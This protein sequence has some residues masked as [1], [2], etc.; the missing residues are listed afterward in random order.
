L[1]V[2]RRLAFA[3]DESVT[4]QTA[5]RICDLTRFGAFACAVAYFLVISARARI[6]SSLPRPR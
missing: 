5:S 6:D 3:R 1:A 2:S 4:E